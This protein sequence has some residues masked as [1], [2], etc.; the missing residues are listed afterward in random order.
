MNRIILVL[1]AAVLLAA[2]VPTTSQAQFKIGPRAT[3]DIG[4]IEEFA[5]GGD[6][7]YEL[8]EA[9]ELPIQLSGAFDFYF[10]GD[11]QVGTDEL[12]R[13]IFTID[14]N[15]HYMF[16]VEGNF[17]PYAGAGIGI[18]SI[19]VGDVSDSDTGIN[20]VGGAEFEVGKSF[21]PFAQAQVTLGG[22]ADR[23]GLTGGLLFA[24]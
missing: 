24:L 16:P 4:D 11:T 22:D 6:V 23:F 17:T 10:A 20:L 19:E 7:R 3:I 15:G 9:T 18:T 12:S 2:A 13:T 21:T 1:L 8:S 5:L 14:L